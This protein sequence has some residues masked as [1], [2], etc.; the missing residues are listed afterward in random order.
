MS[1]RNDLG[2]CAEDLIEDLLKSWGWAVDNVNNGSGGRVRNYEWGDLYA[3]SPS[4]MRLF[5]SVKGRNAIEHSDGRLIY[6]GS[7]DGKGNRMYMQAR[8]RLQVEGRIIDGIG[9][10][11]VAMNLDQTYEAFVGLL[12]QMV[13]TGM[14][15]CRPLSTC[16]T[17]LTVN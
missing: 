17:C 16:R 14:K 3:V 9:W 7:Y 15:G 12:Q 2:A 8:R 4:G 1:F 5:L 10:I 13:V 11:A 6:N